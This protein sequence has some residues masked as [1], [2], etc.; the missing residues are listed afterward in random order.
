M[1]P[2]GGDAYYSPMAARSASRGGTPGAGVHLLDVATDEREAEARVIPPPPCSVASSAASQQR[3]TPPRNRKR[4][5]PAGRPARDSPTPS[6][7]HRT[8]PG[9]GAGLTTL[10]LPAPSASPPFTLGD[11]SRWDAD[12]MARFSPKGG[13]AGTVSHS[14]GASGLARNVSPSVPIRLPADAAAAAAAAAAGGGGGS[15]FLSGAP[16]QPRKAAP[17]SL[18]PGSAAPYDRR[19]AFGRRV[20]R[21]PMRPPTQ[22]PPAEDS[23]GSRA[24]R[25]ECGRERSTSPPPAA[26]AAAAR[27]ERFSSFL[28]G[29]SVSTAVL[30]R[31]LASPASRSTQQQKSLGGGGG[32]GP[33]S[34]ASSDARM[35]A[36]LLLPPALPAA[37]PEMRPGAS[38][39]KRVVSRGRSPSF[40]GAV[41]QQQQLQ[42][43]RQPNAPPSESAGSARPP[44]RGALDEANDSNRTG[45]GAAR[46]PR[47]SPHATGRTQQVGGGFGK[48]TSYGAAALVPSGWQRRLAPAASAARTPD[49]GHLLKPS[50]CSTASSFLNQPAAAP[51]CPSPAGFGLQASPRLSPRPVVGAELPRMPCSAPPFTGAASP[52][53]PPPPPPPPG[54]AAGRD[55][56]AAPRLSPALPPCTPP[57]TA[58]AAAAADQQQHRPAATPQGLAFSPT[59]G[60][61]AGRARE[62]R[63]PRIDR[64]PAGSHG[65]APTSP[66]AA[67][68]PAPEPKKEACA[69]PAAPPSAAAKDG[70]RES[71]EMVIA[72]KD[73]L[74]D[75]FS[76]GR[77]S[78]QT[79]VREVA[80]LSKRRERYA[81]LGGGDCA[82]RPGDKGPSSGCQPTK[83]A[84]R[85]TPCAPSQ[86]AHLP[87]SAHPV[88]TR[89][90]PPPPTTPGSLLDVTDSASVVDHS[91]QCSVEEAKRR[92]HRP[93]PVSATIPALG[94]AVGR[95][96]P[97]PGSTS[98]PGKPTP[99]APPPA[100]DL[101]D[102]CT[103]RH[104][105]KN[106][107]L[108]SVLPLW[109]STKP[110]AADPLAKAA[111]LFPPSGA[112]HTPNTKPAD[113]SWRKAGSPPTFEHTHTPGQQIPSAASPAA[114]ETTDLRQSSQSDGVG[115]EPAEP[116]LPWD[117][118]RVADG[119]NGRRGN[120]Q[121]SEEITVTIEPAAPPSDVLSAFGRRFVK[122]K[123]SARTA[124]GPPPSVG[125]STTC[126]DER[127]K[128]R[129]MNEEPS[130]CTQPENAKTPNERQS[131]TDSSCSDNCWRK[132][133]AMNE[134]HS[135][136]DSSCDGWMKVRAMHEVQPTVHSSWCKQPENAKPLNDGSTTDFSRSD[137]WRKVRAMNEGQTTAHSSW[138]QQQETAKAPNDGQ[139]A[140]DSSCSDDR[141][142]LT[143]AVLAST[144]CQIS[145]ARDVAMG[146][147]HGQ[148]SP[149]DQDSVQ[150]VAVDSPQ[151]AEAARGVCSTPAA[152]AS[153]HNYGWHDAA[154]RIFSA[155]PPSAAHSDCIS[156]GHVASPNATRN[157]CRFNPTTPP[158]LLQD[159]DNRMHFVT[160][161]G[162]AGFFY[163][164]SETLPR[165][166]RRNEPSTPFQSCTKSTVWA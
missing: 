60:A 153:S 28:Q 15:S 124:E 92:V 19:D 8:P 84:Q 54:G 144:S 50:G 128:A 23:Q 135:T 147:A 109:T 148:W 102:Y 158:S 57:V 36:G 37:T 27:H 10:H 29:A 82:T 133:R 44:S 64:N 20:L 26:A 118:D 34:G 17:F 90:T 154:K 55:E 43:R 68:A 53:P 48:G 163:R 73:I 164:G 98:A 140:V 11:A 160:N 100:G 165:N 152:G 117:G 97:V 126:S 32:G 24:S 88:N 21:G 18:Q 31:P 65:F 120:S 69:A 166:E 89:R 101:P 81:E 47:L 145:T 74:F 35:A 7:T 110:R 38:P 78:R 116:P 52:P 79:Y 130:W 159:R 149:T 40:F 62:S 113:P 86:P 70:V 25:S 46:A 9:P 122:K 13:R 2:A 150:V 143:S 103:L 14:C 61:A 119:R 146:G 16:P 63:E 139:L 107:E 6:P 99:Q 96:S 105:Q 123:A 111:V 56:P 39:E 76:A 134:G 33:S 67:K 41:Q 3:A 42:R 59:A 71:A 142:L 106:P 132:A 161:D 108:S 77:I 115:Y 93:D 30:P 127:T 4:A 95:S 49:R 141:K 94:P 129:T 87:S 80:E 91:A 156:T 58:A 83:G 162:H 45:S 22:H 138:C 112:P 12:Q 75:A 72:A 151:F 85:A 121:D 155:P 125:S 157:L 66:A 1:D 104:Q 114:V 131:T 51:R 137:D 136:I 5:L